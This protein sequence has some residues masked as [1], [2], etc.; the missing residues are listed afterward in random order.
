M[1]KL[2]ALAMVVVMLFTAL[3]V[4]AEEGQMAPLYATVGEALEDSAEG[5]VVAGSIPGE[6]YAVVTQ[7]D[8]KYYR[9]VAICDEKLNE[10]NEALENLDYEAEDFFEK[11]EAAMQAVDDYLKTLP[12]AYSEVFTAQPLTDEEMASMQ[13]KSLSQLTE[14]GFEIGSNGTEPSEDEEEILIVYSLRY[15]VYDYNCVVDADFDQYIAAQDNGAEGD[16]VVKSMSLAGIT[17]WGFEKRFHTDGTV[18]E[19]KDPF[20]DFSEIMAEMLTFFEK[21]QAGEEIDI[22]DY[23]DTLK[24]KY[25]DYA[26]MIDVYIT[27]YQTYGAEGFASMM[28]PAE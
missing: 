27:M 11:H 16:L 1:K 15:G 20:A 4:L 23:A 18:D 14:E 19:P 25:P 17:E 7:K 9:S 8:G 26:E 21:I 12:I 3:G 13:G 24:A 2:I 5:R 10:L 22:Q 28:N 6:Y